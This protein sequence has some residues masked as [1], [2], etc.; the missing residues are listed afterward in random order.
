LLHA[1]SLMHTGRLADAGRELTSLE[2]AY[3]QERKVQV[4]LAFLDLGQNR[5]GP[6]E[7]RFRKLV[8]ENPGDT[9][10]LSGLLDVLAAKGRLDEAIPV[11]QESLDRS[12]E[13]DGVRSLLADTALRIGA[14]DLALA[15][16]QQL[17]TSQPNQDRP[18]V[19][20]GLAH[21]RKQDLPS[22]IANFQK[23]ST[24]APN[25]P[26]PVV[27]LAQTLVSAGRIPEA[28]RSYRRALE[29]Q[30]DNAPIMNDLAYEI[31]EGGGNLDEALEL[32]QRAL[33]KNYQQ[34]QFQD[35][36]GWIYFKK[37]VSDSAVQIFRSLID[38]YPDNPT[39][40]YHLGMALLQKGDKIIAR[41]ELKNGLSKRPSPELRRDI[42]AALR[43]AP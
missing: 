14:L 43:A 39:F 17:A 4:Q 16:Y 8:R 42:E 29:L 23:A 12:P 34:P 36:V 37:H 31:V 10:A 40:R 2:K 9:G 25:D 5:L 32:A 26:A 38:R 6:S 15:Q 27:L 21:W 7:E 11:L 28:I 1:I 19:G 20:L 33:K 18:Y 22:A 24:L 35:T 13:S 30:P 3:P 41:A